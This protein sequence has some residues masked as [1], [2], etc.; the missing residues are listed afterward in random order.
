MSSHTF[1]TRKHAA[2][3]AGVDVVTI[4]RAAKSGQL[5]SAKFGHARL[6]VR[7]DLVRWIGERGR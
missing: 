4:D 3:L 6:I 1:L 7:A 2:E 5:E